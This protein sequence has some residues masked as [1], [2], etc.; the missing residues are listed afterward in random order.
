MQDII[1]SAAKN[2]LLRNL[3]S[4]VGLPTPVP[5]MRQKD[6]W[7]NESLHNKKIVYWGS[8]SENNN[9]LLTPLLEAGGEIYT[10]SK[11]NDALKKIAT[12]VGTE[13]RAVSKLAE[14]DRVYALVLD[15]SALKTPDSFQTFYE[16]FNAHL[17]RVEQNGRILVVSTCARGSDLVHECAI[18]G[19]IRSIAK[20]VGAKAITANA[21]LGEV[22]DEKA[23]ATPVLFFLSR[24]SCY[25]SGQILHLSAT[26]TAPKEIQRAQAL[27]GKVALVTGAARG[28]G[29]KIARALARE[30]ARVVCLDREQEGDALARVARSIDGYIFHQDLSE[31]NAAEKISQYF[32]TKFKGCDILIHN[33]G[34]TQDKT[35]KKMPKEK[36][37]RVI[38]I[39]LKAPIAITEQMLK[40][41]S[42][43]DGCRV[44]CL[45]S[46]A[47]IAGNFGQ[48]N[49]ATS[50]AG[51]RGYVASMAT[52]LAKTHSTIN[53][54]APGFIETKMTE[55]IPL[56]TREAGRR[57]NNL[58]QG[59]H[60]ED[61]AEVICFLSQPGVFGVN[62]ETL[63][64]CGGS[65][66]GA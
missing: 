61:V 28:I 21:L 49:Y 29:E 24:S 37:Q 27:K 51:L 10:D 20:E 56:V 58:G 31:A 40:D 25:V 4:Q 7:V 38:D 42:L 52:T 44:V 15:A 64:V 60:P 3:F 35:L 41:K 46:I 55:T 54:V 50:K 5:L 13:I 36:W 66:L 19:F 39:N 30:G 17:A 1:L 14:H 12:R 34:I 43:N 33:A 59:G 57:L 48:T 16:F 22:K 47:G 45:S 2:P 63:R 23:L 53:A 26:A 62:G 32:K 8:S 65:I 6:A 9:A 18:E 11:T